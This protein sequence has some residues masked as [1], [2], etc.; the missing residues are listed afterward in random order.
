[1]ITRG[2]IALFAGMLLLALVIFMPLSLALSILG[3]EAKGISARSASGTIWS[4]RLSEARLGRLAL[5][6]VEVGL[7]PLSLL[8][9]QARI[10]MQSLFGRGS[11]TSTA[12]GYSID[13]ATARVSTA[14]VF[15]PIPLDSVDLTAV[16]VSFE[17][18]KCQKAEGRLR[19]SFSGEVGSLSLAQGLS[20]TI[21]CDNGALLLPLISQSAMERL[22]LH[23]Q[24]DGDYRAEFFVRS[25]DPL[26]A[27]KL[28][29]AGFT[30]SAGGFVF[31]VAGKL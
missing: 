10:D 24:G 17:S 28:G 1:M 26:L 22:N 3:L 12:K 5:G 27:G 18:G 15:A 19:A 30:P 20:G 2:R 23:I 9:G 29:S 14:G 13:D 21:R 16:S 25:T 6:D 8:I 31:R 11:M 4:G 7:R